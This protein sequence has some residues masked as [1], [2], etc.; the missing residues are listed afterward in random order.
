M[1]NAFIKFIVDI[2]SNDAIAAV[3][4]IVLLSVW[5]LSW[6]FVINPLIKNI[7][8]IGTNIEKH[9]QENNIEKMAKDIEKIKER[10]L[11]EKNIVE[12]INYI[13]DFIKTN[14]TLINIIKEIDKNTSN[15]VLTKENLNSI[16]QDLIYIKKYIDRNFDNHKELSKI[17]DQIKD[18]LKYIEDN[19]HSTNN[20]DSKYMETAL[21]II[22]E[23]LGHQTRTRFEKID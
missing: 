21:K 8:K 6:K 7:Q 16:N 11:S 2:M 19:K 9:F 1:N 18:I 10:Q 12:D 17:S 22:L 15:I 3:I 4:L 13:T 23:G 14:T 5:W 20:M